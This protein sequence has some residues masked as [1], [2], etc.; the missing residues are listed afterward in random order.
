MARESSIQDIKDAYH[1]A[2]K[3]M[4]KA[5]ALYR[6]GSKLSQPLNTTFQDNPEL[7]MILESDEAE[8]EPVMVEE[9]TWEKPIVATTNGGS[10]MENNVVNEIPEHEKLEAPAVVVANGDS[11]IGGAEYISDERSTQ[12]EMKIIEEDQ[13]IGDVRTAGYVG[14]EEKCHECGNKMLR[15]NGVCTICDVCGAT[16]GCS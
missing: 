5:V 13:Q 4:G 9:R 10:E 8:E 16:G 12:E 11:A 7:K 2:W 15:Q 14:G 3:H 6:D 1:Y